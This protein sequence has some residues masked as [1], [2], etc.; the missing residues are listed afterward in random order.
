MND[1]TGTSCR[2]IALQKA[3]NRVEIIRVDRHVIIHEV[4]DLDRLGKTLNRLISLLRQGGFARIRD[5]ATETGE[6]LEDRLVGSTSRGVACVNNDHETA[7]G[8]LVRM[9]ALEGRR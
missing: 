1:S 8:V 4:Y 3:T 7:I 9:D 2:R 5:V 6:G